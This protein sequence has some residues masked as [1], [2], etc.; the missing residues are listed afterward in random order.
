MLLFSHVL[1]TLLFGIGETT[2]C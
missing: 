2:A 1:F